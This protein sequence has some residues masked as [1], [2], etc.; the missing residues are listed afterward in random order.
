MKKN[1]VLFAF[2]FIGVL[3][4]SCGKKIDKTSNN[5]GENFDYDLSDMNY[6]IVSSMNFDMAINPEKYYNKT[7]KMK[8]QFFSLEEDGGKRFYSCVVYDPTVCCQAGIDFV[9]STDKKYP[10]DFPAEEAYIE[11]TG[12]YTDFSS[13]FE[14]GR[15][16][17][18]I[19][20]DEIKV[21][22]K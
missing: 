12:P 2:L 3:F 16:Y 11:I 17:S 19:L 9:M 22:K 21:I 20:C 1:F 6:N 18:G 13:F 15:S 4:N 14:D 8:G 7:I 10:D 5:N